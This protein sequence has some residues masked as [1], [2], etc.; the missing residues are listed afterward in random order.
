MDA[1]D[2]HVDGEK[3]GSPQQV[4]DLE[5]GGAQLGIVS[6]MTMEE[7]A[8]AYRGNRAEHETGVFAAVRIYWR[9]LFWMV[10]MCTVSLLF[11]PFIAFDETE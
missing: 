10:V 6:N 4:E 3:H 9:A 7:V 1:M 2:S 8:N 11:Q 5:S